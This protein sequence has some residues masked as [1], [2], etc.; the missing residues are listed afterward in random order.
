MA[1]DN[2]VNNK[3]IHT[4]TPNKLEIESGTD[5]RAIYKCFNNFSST[6]GNTLANNITKKSHESQP[7]LQKNQVN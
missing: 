3:I 1:S 4:R 5:Q 2:L 6:I 7:F